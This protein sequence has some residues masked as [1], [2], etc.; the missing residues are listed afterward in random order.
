M[1]SLV[2]E[3]NLTKLVTEFNSVASKAKNLNKKSLNPLKKSRTASEAIIVMDLCVFHNNL[4]NILRNDG[5]LIKNYYYD[6]S[7][8]L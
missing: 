7:S 2:S 3:N 8:E 5:V 4:R 1:S 6:Y